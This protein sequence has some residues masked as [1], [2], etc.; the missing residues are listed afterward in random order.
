MIS[1][2]NF[3]LSCFKGNSCLKGVSAILGKE[4]RKVSIDM[5][6]FTILFVLFQKSQRFFRYSQHLFFNLITISIVML[7]LISQHFQFI[8]SLSSQF[9]VFGIQIQVLSSQSISPVFEFF[10][11][12]SKIVVGQKDFVISGLVNFSLQNILLSQ[13]VFRDIFHL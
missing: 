9:G 3:F 10:V 1:F 11:C 6:N 2:F 13:H 12:L 8:L 7:Q 4:L 5:D